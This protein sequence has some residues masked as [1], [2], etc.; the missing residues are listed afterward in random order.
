MRAIA[1]FSAAM[2]HV[3]AETVHSR[4]VLANWEAL[5]GYVGVELGYEPVEQVRVL[6]LNTRNT[7]IVD[8]LVARGSIDQCPV[9]PR[10]V[11]GR[12]LQVGS[13]ALILVHN[14]PGGDPC[15]SAADIAVTR[16]LK[17]SLS[18]FGISLHDHLIVARARHYSMR[19]A[20]LL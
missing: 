3:L 11:V 4:P 17:Q 2:Q 19:T 14:H 18:V 8:D 7:L 9:F 12:A 16:C 6:H 20:G 1:Q 5:L 13:A 15:A 10:E